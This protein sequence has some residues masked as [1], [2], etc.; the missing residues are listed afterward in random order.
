MTTRRAALAAL[1]AGL[2]TGF[3]GACTVARDERLRFGLP[4]APVT[5]D[6]RFA[7]DAMSYRLVRLLH[8]APVDFDAA[9]EPCADLAD[10]SQLAPDRYRFTVREDAH[11]DDG[12]AVIADDVAATYR[13]VLHAAN[14][15]PHRGS[16]ANVRAIERV[17]RRQLD[18][19]L[20]RPDPLFPGTLVVGVLAARDLANDAGRDRWSRSCGACARMQHA[21]D[22]NVL[23]RRRSDG[24]PVEFVTVKDPSVRALKLVG[25]EL[26]IAQ[27]N[28]APEMYAW[29]AERSGLRGLSVPGST[30]SYLG[31]NLD[32]P[33]SGRLEV[34][35]AIAHALD[36]AA[37]VR[38]LF[39]G[40]ARLAN[41]LFPPEHWAGDPALVAPAHDLGAAREQLDAAGYAGRR[42]RLE[43]KTSS[44]PF[45]LRIAAVMRQQLAAVGID[46][47]IVSYDWGTFY[48]DVSH[49][50]FQLY[51]LSWV[52]LRLPDVFRYAFHSSS[53]P[54]AGA[55]RGNYRSTAVDGL[56]ER[57]E[58]TDDRV[59]RVRLYRAIAATL[60]D[61]LPYV[62]L[63]FEDQ[64]VITRGDI[65]DYTTDPTGNFD[66]LAR[67]TRRATHV[68]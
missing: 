11:F 59:E 48:G 58:R 29:L 53:R 17:D 1:G 65:E 45:R 2:A 27:G 61:D 32:D 57:A 3:L 30:F 28:L 46:L 60:L 13:S 62:P 31:F 47:D 66:A 63:W 41:T 21:P 12:R 22:G 4:T 15:S 16:L 34:R 19:V 36:R 68:G 9:G 40:H 54:P 25:G 67:T 26:D 6:P 39:G 42:L 52:G 8:R 14:A 43:Y 37:I 51:G 44:D 7:A 33:V 50:R 5:L 38:H 64:L 20:A 10:W 49:G 18:F 35:R 24:Q 23:M 56:I 55:N